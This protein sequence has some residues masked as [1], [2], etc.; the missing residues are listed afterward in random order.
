MLTTL[1]TVARALIGTTRA[2]LPVVCIF[3]HKPM[4]LT[5]PTADDYEEK[6]LDCRCY[7]TDT[8]LERVLIRDRPDV[9]ITNGHRSAFPH[10]ATIRQFWSATHR[11]VAPGSHAPGTVAG[12]DGS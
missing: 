5:T 2:K 3:G 9:I 6:R 1:K 12:P 7:A 11:A 10:L 8:D 4:T